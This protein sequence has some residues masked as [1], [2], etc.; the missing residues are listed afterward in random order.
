MNTK[1][2]I[3]TVFAFQFIVGLS[4]A[5]WSDWVAPAEADTLTNTIP[6]ADEA[7][8]A[9]GQMMWTS[10]CFLCHGDTGKGDGLQ[11]ASLSK[12]PA[13]LT[14]PQVQRQ[15]DGAL[16]W[17]ITT[18][19]DPM[20]AFDY[21]TEEQRWQLVHYI[22]SLASEDS[23][24]EDALAGKGSNSEDDGEI[25]EGESYSPF[26]FNNPND[27]YIVLIMGL[28]LFVIV[29]LLLTI[30]VTLKVMKVVKGEVE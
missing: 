14:S 23:G 16:F 22:R 27:I 1:K 5:Q 11:A 10:M 30:R 24:E 13:D 28:V 18:G 20:L 8:L 19:N 25:A 17:K 15:S 29:A 12:P 26:D 2:I 9:E 6:E 7:V 4:Y 3:L 21:Y